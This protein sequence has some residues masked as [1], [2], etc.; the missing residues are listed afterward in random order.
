MDLERNI[1][2]FVSEIESYNSPNLIV[3]VFYRPPDSHAVFQEEFE[4]FLRSINT[5]HSNKKLLI[6]GDFNFPKIDWSNLPVS[7]LSGFELDF[8][9]ILKDYFLSQVVSSPTRK[10]NNDTQNILDLVITNYSDNIL[11]LDIVD[12]NNMQFPTDHSL[13]LFDFIS[14]VYFISKAYKKADFKALRETL[15]SIL[16]LCF[17]Q[18]DNIDDDWQCWYDLFM[19]A[20]DQ[21]VPKVKIRD[22]NSPPWIDS[23]VIRLLHKK[24]AAR[25]RI[26]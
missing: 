17:L 18:N 7:S 5:L 16:F 8:C 6:L 24:D 4:A 21:H 11:H 9:E 10:A 23:E 15:Q 25:T 22:V 3:A 2:M 13:I 20:V 1:E 26:V 14:K 12:P 19:T